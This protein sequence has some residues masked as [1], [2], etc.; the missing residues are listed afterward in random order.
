MRVMNS[1]KIVFSF[2]PQSSKR[3]NKKDFTLWHYTFLFLG[4]AFTFLLAFSFSK[5]STEGNAEE[6]RKEVINYDW[7]V[8]TTTEK[9][10]VELYLQ[11]NITI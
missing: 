1:L 8:N 5:F 9:R 2:T 3:N 4:I 11:A 10:N 6:I 7:V